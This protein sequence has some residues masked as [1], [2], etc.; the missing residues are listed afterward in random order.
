MQRVCEKDEFGGDIKFEIPEIKRCPICRR[1]V[2]EEEVEY[3][4]KQVCQH[5][6]ID[7]HGYEIKI[8]SLWQ[9]NTLLYSM[10][11]WSIDCKDALNELYWFLN[12]L[13]TKWLNMCV[14]NSNY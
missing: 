10:A 1:E 2:E 3:I 9:P 8:W 12:K 14:N 4:K 13:N 5:P 7:D 6:E 11:L